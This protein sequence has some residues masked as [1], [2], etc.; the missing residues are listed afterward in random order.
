MQK[1]DPTVRGDFLVNAFHHAWL[2]AL[3]DE[4]VTSNNV[5]SAP[6]ELMQA[7]LV[8]LNEV[9]DRDAS[10]LGKAAF[11]KWCSRAADDLDM[12]PARPN[13]QLH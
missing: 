7:V 12:T 5:A 4:L 10:T 6:A 1:S 9:A 8:S 13:E 2:H 3:Q 11:A